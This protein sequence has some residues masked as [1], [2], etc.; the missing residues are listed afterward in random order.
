[1]KVFTLAPNKAL[2]VAALVYLF[3]VIMFTYI[4][5]Q[6][7]KKN[8]YASL[9][10]QLISAANLTPILLPKLFHRHEMKPGD[11]SIEQDQRIRQRLSDFTNNNDIEYIY[12]MVL[13]DGKVFFTSSSETPEDAETRDPNRADYFWHYEDVD[14]RVYEV[15]AT[16]ETTFLE[17]SDQWGAFRSVFIPVTAEDGSVYITAADLSTSHIQALISQKVF[18]SL[19][20]SLLF[21]LFIYPLFRVVTQ[22]EKR[23]LKELDSKV[24]QQ[25]TA[26]LKSENRLKQALKSAEQTWFEINL[27]AKEVTVSSEFP[28]AGFG[29]KYPLFSLD[30]WFDTIHDEDIGKVEQLFK[31]AL[32]DNESLLLTYRVYSQEKNW[33]WL[34]TTADIVEWDQFGEPLTLVGLTTDITER[35]HQEI[36]ARNRQNQLLRNQ[37][38]LLELGREKFDDELAA[39]NKVTAKTAEQLEVSRVGVWYFNKAHSLITSKSMYFDGKVSNE[40]QTLLATDYPNYFKALN[41]T[42]FISASDAEHHPATCEFTE[43]YLKPL[44]IKSM[45]DTPITIQGKIVGVVCYEQTGSRREW[46]PQDIDFAR[47]IAD[48]VAQEILEIKRQ[49]AEAELRHYQEHLEELIEARTIEIQ[50][51]RDDA[52]K[53]NKAKSQFLSSM[54]HELRTPM[55]SI[56]GFTQLLELESS[57]E[58]QEYL[59]IIKES[60]EHL[61]T[62]IN[63][64]LDLSKIESGHVNVTKETIDI[65]QLIPQ[66][67]ALVASEASKKD[68]QLSNNVPT[69]T[70]LFVKTDETKLK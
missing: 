67:I 35:K 23:L 70:A 60:G 32:D 7:E 17:Y 52:E 41:M 53:A 8:L 55:N 29:E 27:Q 24:Q 1:M 43:S 15:F 59:K 51:A 65:S 20:Y 18:R 14:P 26:L 44:N 61:L 13:S 39:L 3:W 28:V 22:Q 12:T 46:S 11:I 64:V 9:D 10:Q 42:G 57:K 38:L 19:L 5:T 69:E 6:N 34:Q 4:S 45:L 54:S 40:A 62:L 30:E 37:Q 48:L 63:G 33:V 56:L 47:A 50:Q 25:T 16:Q 21:I 49:Q 68:I 36:N 58:Q 31:Q 2:T 66:V